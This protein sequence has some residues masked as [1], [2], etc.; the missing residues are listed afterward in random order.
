MVKTCILRNIKMFQAGTD[1]SQRL[2]F[3]VVVYGCETWS[4]ISKEEYEF[5]VS[6]N[7]VLKRIFGPKRCKVIGGCSARNGPVYAGIPYR[8]LSLCLTHIPALINIY[9]IHLSFSIFLTAYP[10]FAFKK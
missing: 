1:S 3:P 6:E 9:Y 5:R 10:C 8:N 4:P 2:N 7:R